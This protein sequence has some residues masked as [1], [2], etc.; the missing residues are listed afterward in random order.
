M[1]RKI[2][3]LLPTCFYI[4][5]M[6]SVC[7][8]SLLAWRRSFLKRGTLLDQF[9]SFPGS[10]PRKVWQKHVTNVWGYAFLSLLSFINIHQ[11]VLDHCYAFD[12][13][14]WDSGLKWKLS[15]EGDPCDLF[16]PCP[17]SAPRLIWPKN[18]TCKGPW[19]LHT[20]QVSLKSIQ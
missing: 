4:I 19:I 17:E 9:L 18:N 11:A 8:C 13:L 20:Y 10:A 15:E 14:M 7:C 1:E 2:T 12:S 16:L 3:T 6:H 5:A